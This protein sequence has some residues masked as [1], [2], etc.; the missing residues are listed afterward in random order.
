MLTFKSAIYKSIVMLNFRIWRLEVQRTEESIGF[1]IGRTE[2]YIRKVPAS[3]KR[4][5]TFCCWPVEKRMRK[6]KIKGSI[7]YAQGKKSFLNTDA[8]LNFSW[9][10]TFECKTLFFQEFFQN[11]HLH[12][13]FTSK[14][15]AK[16]VESIFARLSPSTLPKKKY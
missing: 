9:K 6:I 16:E 2:Y 15:D 13:F 1:R 10:G 14:I 3:Q 7:F 8:S 4:K 12:L 11:V 5:N